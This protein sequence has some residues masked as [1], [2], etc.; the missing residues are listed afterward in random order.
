MQ[1]VPLLVVVVLLS[2]CA[3]LWPTPSA[4]DKTLLAVAQECSARV[5]GTQVRGVDSYG[6]VNYMYTW[7]QERMAFE[8]CYFEGAKARQVAGPV[9]RPIATLIGRR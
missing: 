7:E 9:E 2:G 8:E 4:R 3:L 1:R 5:H 6:R